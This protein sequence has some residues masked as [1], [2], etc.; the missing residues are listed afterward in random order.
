MSI[1]GM[2]DLIGDIPMD[3][4]VA[5][6][7]GHGLDSVIHIPAAA[8]V[9]VTAVVVIVAGLAD[10]AMAMA[11]DIDIAVVAKTN[12]MTTTLRIL[13]LDASLHR[14]RRNISRRTPV[15]TV[16]FGS[17]ADGR[18]GHDG[19]ASSS[20]R[21]RSGSGGGG[22]SGRSSSSRGCCVDSLCRRVG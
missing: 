1:V 8:A 17:E 22:G 5:A 21:S 12:A 16:G 7:L 11:I 6:T 9:V 10:S 13:F 20:P 14:N 2:G 19:G 4:A 18:F 3:N 15:A